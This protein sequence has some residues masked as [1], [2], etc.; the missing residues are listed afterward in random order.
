[1]NNQKNPLKLKILFT[2]GGTG[3]HVFPI[4]AIAEEIKKKNP[5]GAEIKL[6]FVGPKDEISD[7]LFKK[8]G[9]EVKKIITG[10]IRRYSSFSSIFQNLID[11]FFKI[12][13]G[14]IQSF[15]YIFFLSPDLL[16]S[17]GGFGA[18]PGTIAAKV[19]QVP[20]F[21]HE[22]DAV[23]G[24][25][26]KISARFALEIFVSFPKTENLPI[27]KMILV[28]NPIRKSLINIPSK[29]EIEKEINLIKDKPVIFVIGGSQGS[30][31]VNDLTLN[32]LP[33]L[34]PNYTVI[35]Q[36]GIN[37]EKEIIMQTDFLIPKE[38][39]KNYFLF[40]FLTKEQLRAAYHVSDIVISRAGSGSIFEIAA[41]SKPSILIPI[42]EAAQNHQ[43]KNAYSYCNFGAGMVV[44]EK[45]ITPHLFAEK[46]INLINN[47]NTLKRMK[48][49]AN[50]F[51]RPRSAEIISEYALE[52]LKQYLK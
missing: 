24:I 8:E 3:G 6:Y 44:E 31:R 34:L 50:Y 35:H 19:L 9:I 41:V 48:R 25:V 52:F 22:S 40:S 17:K 12:P 4:L 2:G 47:E 29:N 49:K 13:F 32:V 16:I 46:I 20:I 1:M 14:I 42:T 36:C 18:F 45:N 21:L 39:K 37:N 33:Q 10:K 51:S 43:I 7:N 38:L 5:E 11:L 27:E 23:S 15:F 28:G 30:E 26:N